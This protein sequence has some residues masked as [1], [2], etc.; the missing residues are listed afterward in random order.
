MELESDS[1]WQHEVV[2][3]K[4]V[5]KTSSQQSGD[6]GSQYFLVRKKQF[7]EFA[8]LSVTDNKRVYMLILYEIILRW[9]LGKT[10]EYF[11]G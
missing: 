9:V 5:E 8:L 2:A 6:R 3:Q 1:I 10:T 7:Q 4:P 11:G